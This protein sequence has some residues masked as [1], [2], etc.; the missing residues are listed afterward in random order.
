MCERRLPE[1]H[2]NNLALTVLHV[3]YS[4]D[5][6]G[7]RRV[8]HGTREFFIDNLLVHIHYIIVMIK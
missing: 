6:G 8:C 5:S 1:R 7:L 4:L 2:G 3:P